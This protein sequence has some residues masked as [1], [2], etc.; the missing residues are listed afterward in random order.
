L[1]VSTAFQATDYLVVLAEED[2]D[3]EEVQAADAGV[4]GTESAASTGDGGAPG[5]GDGQPTS[6]DSWQ[7][8]FKRIEAAW[9]AGRSLGDA[10]EAVNFLQLL[11]DLHFDAVAPSDIL[12]A[13]DRIRVRAVHPA[14]GIH[15]EA[16]VDI[17]WENPP[18]DVARPLRKESATTCAELRRLVPELTA[19]PLPAS[20]IQG[21]KVVSLDVSVIASDVHEFTE[22]LRCAATLVGVAAIDA[23]QAAGQSLQ[24]RLAGRTG[25]TLTLGVEQ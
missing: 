22:L 10:H 25:S 4:K 6:P 12:A 17:L 14:T 18:N 7:A 3:E 9:L 21:E 16:L 2:G 11:T 24:G 20:Q 8:E 15:A 1:V 5:A 19:D 13:F 23:L